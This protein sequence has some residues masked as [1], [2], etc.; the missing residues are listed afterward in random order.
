MNPSISGGGAVVGESQHSAPKLFKG[1]ISKRRAVI[2][3]MLFAIVGTITLLLSAANTLQFSTDP[4]T[5]ILQY[6][7]PHQLMPVQTQKLTKPMYAPF[8]LYGN[9]LLICGQN[10]GDQF[11]AVQS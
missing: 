2:F 5:V 11:N 10:G 6:A 9:G 3:A 8:T 7:L 4:N 1:R